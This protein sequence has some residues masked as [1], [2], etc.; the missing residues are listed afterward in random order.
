MRIN[1]SL[2]G[3][4]KLLYRKNLEQSWDMVRTI[5]GTAFINII[6]VLKPQLTSWKRNGFENMGA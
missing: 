5:E 4:S 3:L 1:G 6:I 2:W